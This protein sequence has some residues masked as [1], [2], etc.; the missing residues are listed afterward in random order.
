[1]REEA[2]DGVCLEDHAHFGAIGFFYRD[3]RQISDEEGSRRSSAFRRS[4]SN[5]SSQM[6]IGGDKMLLFLQ[7][8]NLLCRKCCKA[9]L[10]LIGHAPGRDNP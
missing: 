1:M 2:D 8:L 4:Q 6:S 5:G 7:S 3:F 10:A 9:F